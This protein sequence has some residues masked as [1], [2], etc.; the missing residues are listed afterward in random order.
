MQV[1]LDVCAHIP[2]TLW[3]HFLRCVR[4]NESMRTHDVI[5]DTF[6]AIVRDVCFHIGREQLQA[7]PSTMFNS[8][9]R[10]FDIM[11]TKD[12][13]CTLVNVAIT[14]PTWMD[15]LSQFCEIL[16]FV[17]SNAI[18]AKEMSYRDRY[19]TNQFLPLGIEIFAYPHKHVDMFSH[20]CANAIW[21]L[22]R[23]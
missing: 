7:V 23:P 17:V 12:D 11:F 9:C 3:V 19:P 14:N 1:S 2:S 15:L 18:K 4:G 8:F 20:H 22:K 13:I 5:H 6:V 16:R 10:Q 21:N